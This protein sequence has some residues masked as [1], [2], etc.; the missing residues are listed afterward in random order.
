[1]YS[2]C[3][4]QRTRQSPDKKS[5]D[6][7]LSQML[8]DIL[9]EECLASIIQASNQC[10][11]QKTNRAMVTLAKWVSTYW[12]KCPKMLSTRTV[13]TINLGNQTAK[14]TGGSIW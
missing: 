8:F 14:A 4:G 11:H 6:G 1:M 5:D 7:N 9:T 2:H 13:K 10:N 3:E 12:P